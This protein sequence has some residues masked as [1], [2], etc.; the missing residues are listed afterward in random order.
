MLNSLIWFVFTQ[1]GV[2]QAYVCHAE[3]NGD[4]Y[5]HIQSPGFEKLENLLSELE[6]SVMENAPNLPK[7]PIT[8]DN[9]PEQLYFGKYK[10]DN[11]WYRIKILEWAPNRKFA[12]IYFV[13]YGNCDIIKMADETLYPL[14]ELSDVID[15]F[16]PQAVRVKMQM[17]VVPG[18]FVEM[19]NKL[20]PKEQAVLLKVV[21]ESKDG[22]PVVQFFTRIGPNNE[23]CYINQ[24]IVFET[25]KE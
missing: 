13:D 4:V 16:P 20:M 18:N 14:N 5:V 6:A 21:D 1:S 25:E 24:S 11:R 7:K 8:P 10:E 17:E 12:Q 22:I 15:R 19:V 2:T 9:N 3:S 23:L